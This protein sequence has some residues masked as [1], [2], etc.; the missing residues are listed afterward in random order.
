LHEWLADVESKMANI[1]ARR[2]GE[3]IALTRQQARALAG[4]W[5]DWS[6][7]DIDLERARDQLLDFAA[8]FCSQADMSFCTA[9][10]RL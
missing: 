8:G 3:G 9:H 4:E 1:V 2:T 10:V 7:S 6:S 5:Y